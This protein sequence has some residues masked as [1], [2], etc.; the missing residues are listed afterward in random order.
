M[1]KIVLAFNSMA[2]PDEPLETG[3]WNMVQVLR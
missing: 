3:M 2:V 1:N